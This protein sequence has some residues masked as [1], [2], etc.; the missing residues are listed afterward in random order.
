LN[1]I[2]YDKSDVIINQ[3]TDDY[4]KTLR[5]LCND[6]ETSKT[7]KYY[8]QQAE[9]G[10]NFACAYYKTNSSIKKYIAHSGFNNKDKFKYLNIFKS[11]YTIGFRPELI[12]RENIF[13]TKTYNEKCNSASEKW[14]RWDDTESK[15]LE[16]IAFEQSEKFT[17]TIILWTQRYPCP[18]CRCVIIDFEKKYG[19]NIK[20]YYET[21]YFTNPCDKGDACDDY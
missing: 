16:Q 5:N 7:D 10:G 21:R 19:I 2:K 6:P 18:S 20:V 14:N 11:K 8:Y 3:I 13:K 15:I 1:I 9:T 12:D 17:E 4:Y